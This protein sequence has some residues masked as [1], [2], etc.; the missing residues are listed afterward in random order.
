MSEERQR[1]IAREGGRAAHQAGTAHEFSSA[2][3]RQA[4]HKGGASVSRDRSHMAEIG[5]KGGES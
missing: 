1:Q 2:E 5:R 3:A 4:G